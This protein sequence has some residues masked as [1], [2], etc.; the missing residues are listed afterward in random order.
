MKLTSFTCG[1]TPLPSKPCPT[2]QGGK[3]ATHGFVCNFLKMRVTSFFGCKRPQV[4]KCGATLPSL[5]PAFPHKIRLAA[6]CCSALIWLNV[7]LSVASIQPQLEPPPLPTHA[8]LA[9]MFFCVRRKKHRND[10]HTPFHT[11]THT[12]LRF[13]LPATPPLVLAMVRIYPRGTSLRPFGHAPHTVPLGFWLT[14]FA[15]FWWCMPQK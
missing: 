8:N 14:V 11:H 12:T 13:T 15:C 5:S 2:E 4:L 6:A 7:L 9:V 1:R 3:P 10:P